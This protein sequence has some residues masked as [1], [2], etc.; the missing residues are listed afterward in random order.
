ALNVTGVVI[1]K[2][3]GTAKGGIVL[4]LAGRMKLPI[5]FLGIGEAAEDFAVFNAEQFVAALLQSD[6]KT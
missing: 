2:L 3:D 4:A 1:T 5:R 6:A